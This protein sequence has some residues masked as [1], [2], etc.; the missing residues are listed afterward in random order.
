[1]L[2]ND[3]LRL[4]PFHF[5]ADPDPDPAFLFDA[6]S[7]SRRKRIRIQ[8]PKMMQIHA[9]PDPQHCS[10]IRKY[11]KAVLF[12]K[13]LLMRELFPRPYST[14]IAFTVFVSRLVISAAHNV[15]VTKRK[16]YKT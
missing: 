14:S 10:F 4:P 12:S 3:H 5:D 11:N 2:Q 8:L 16:S 7:T 15:E 1:M 13:K 6:D 9:D